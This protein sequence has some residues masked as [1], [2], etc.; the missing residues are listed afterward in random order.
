MAAVAKTLEEGIAAHVLKDLQAKTVTKVCLEW[1]AHNQFL[2]TSV[3][4][5]IGTFLFSC[6]G[7]IFTILTLPQPEKTAHISR[8]HHRFS[9]E[10]TS[11]EQAQ[12]S[13]ADDVLSSRSGG[14]F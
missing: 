12:K 7:F 6:H 5:L 4:V 11:G 9:R 3:S 13:H 2:S 8:R 14:C 10:T 1:I